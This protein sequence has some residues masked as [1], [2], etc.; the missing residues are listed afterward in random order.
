MDRGRLAEP[1]RQANLQD[2]AD[3]RLDRRTGD[4]AVETP[5]SRRAPRPEL[6]VDLAS[7][8]IDGHDR[9]SRLGLGGFVRAKV[10]GAPVRRRDMGDGAMRASRTMA[11]MTV[12]VRALIVGFVLVMVGHG[13]SRAVLRANAG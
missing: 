7:L 1:V 6:P 5:R 2:V 9:S 4:L 10:I 13:I 3:L 12:A 8:E 11:S